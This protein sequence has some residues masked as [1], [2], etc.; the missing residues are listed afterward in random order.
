MIYETSPILSWLIFLL[1]LGGAADPAA[2]G[3]EARTWIRRVA[4][5]FTAGTFVLSL[6]AAGMLNLNLTLGGVGN[7]ARTCSW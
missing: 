7:M 2:A 4:L 1:M 6:V 3:G 5:A